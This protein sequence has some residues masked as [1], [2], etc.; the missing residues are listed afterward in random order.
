MAAR[1]GEAVSAT[2]DGCRI[3]VRVHPCARR[4]RLVAVVGGVVKLEVAAR[5]ERGAANLA[6]ERLVAAVLDVAPGRV[7]VTSGRTSRTK[8][9]RVSGLSAGDAM[10]RLEAALEPTRAAAQ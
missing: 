7:A 1:F 4:S 6:V 2:E 5:P 3:A 9:V 10:T 8:S